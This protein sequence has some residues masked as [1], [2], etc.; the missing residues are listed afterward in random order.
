MQQ[1]RLNVEIATAIVLTST[2][3][4]S[5]CGGSDG[6]TDKASS[7]SSSSTAEKAR[8]QFLDSA[9]GNVD[10]YQSGLKVATTDSEG[11]FDYTKGINVTFKL[12]K[13]TLGSTM[14]KKI[15]TPLDLS[16]KPEQ[17]TEILQALQSLDEDKN[18]DN[19][20]FIPTT[21]LDKLVTEKDLSAES[22]SIADT[23]KKDIPDIQIISKEKANAHF[24]KTKQKLGMTQTSQTETN[25]K[26]ETASSDD[27]LSGYW[28]SECMQRSLGKGSKA[29]YMHIEKN[30][31]GSYT[32]KENNKATFTS[33]NCT[34][35]STTESNS[36]AGNS[37][38]S[39]SDAKNVSFSG[40]DKFNVGKET[41]SRISASEFKTP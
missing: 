11:Y 22:V 16:D 38:I 7:S 18:P 5:A 26:S 28:R 20:I 34:G 37:Y 3:L 27:K 4:L 2:L 41:Y 1:K 23:V 29:Y 14:P 9:V 24:A 32:I 6:G 19:G 17:V 30:N 8:G 13:L 10:V 15:V 25:T 40:N 33:N 35:S 39:A 21:T 31:D 12:N 36:D